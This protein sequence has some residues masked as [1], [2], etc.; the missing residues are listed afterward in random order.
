MAVLLRCFWVVLDTVLLALVANAVA[1]L[2]PTFRGVPVWMFAFLHAIAL[3]CDVVAACVTIHRALFCSSKTTLRWLHVVA[4]FLLFAFSTLWLIWIELK[5]APLSQFAT[6][7]ARAWYTLVVCGLIHAF[8]TVL[9]L[10]SDRCLAHSSCGKHRWHRQMKRLLCCC[11]CQTAR[12]IN[13]VVRLEAV[14]EVLSDVFDAHFEDGKPLTAHRLFVALNLLKKKHKRDQQSLSALQQSDHARLLEAQY[15]AKYAQAAYG[16]KM[17][18]LERLKNCVCDARGCC[19]SRHPCWWDLDAFLHTSGCRRRDV[20]LMSS[21]SDW[22][23]GRPAFYVVVDHKKKAIV[24]AVRGTLSIVDVLTD[25]QAKTCALEC[26]DQAG[27]AHVGIYR[28]AHHL[29]MHLMNT[30]AFLAAFAPQQHRYDLIITG[31]S[32]G[33]GVA[34]CLA[35]LM[36]TPPPVVAEAKA[37]TKKP[38]NRLHAYCFG[39]PLLTDYALATR[40]RTCDIITQVVYNDDLVTRLS[41]SNLLKFKQEVTAILASQ[42][43]KTATALPLAESKTPPVVFHLE[44]AEDAEYFAAMTIPAQAP[45]NNIHHHVDPLPTPLYLPGQVYHVVRHPTSKGHSVHRWSHD[46]SQQIRVTKRLLLDHFPSFYR[47]D[48]AKILSEQ[49]IDTA[50]VNI[51]I[52]G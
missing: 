4:S 32:L 51:Q 3:L 30:P 9:T 37:Q 22:A 41:L 34:A 52:N 24:V 45:L 13:E 18:D 29:R 1:I 26:Q 39:C 23:S 40:P 50:S 33:A 35:L 27:W 21:S 10:L 11:F 20:L 14:A 46:S 28:A 6:N 47:V 49:T 42:P 43:S 38:W 44:Y 17:H 2:S 15:Y 36:D 8:A 31:H 7:V 16:W 5:L 48:L 25:A 12:T 19:C